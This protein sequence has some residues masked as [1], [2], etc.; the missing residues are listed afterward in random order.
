MSDEL[1]AP[2][3]MLDLSIIYTVCT[4]VPMRGLNGP[5][6]THLLDLVVLRLILTNLRGVGLARKSSLPGLST[7]G[8][9]A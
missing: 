2:M 1:I 6:L 7:G 9:E 3:G 4:H 5:I 8:S